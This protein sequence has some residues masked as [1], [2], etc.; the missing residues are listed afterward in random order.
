MPPRYPPIAPRAAPTPASNGQ[1]PSRIEQFD[2]LEAQPDDEGYAAQLNALARDHRRFLTA[3]HPIKDALHM[4]LQQPAGT[5][6]A[7]YAATMRRYH[8]AANAPQASDEPG[9][10]QAGTAAEADTRPA[11]VA[12]TE[13]MVAKAILGDTTSQS[14]ISDRIEGKTGLRRADVDAETEAQRLRVRAVIGELVNGMVDRS[15]TRAEPIDVTP[16]D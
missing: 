8:E 10:R 9:E 16:E 3:G 12:F 14:L 11:I 7:R 4:A 6:L 13:T 2:N 15:R 5:L 1:A